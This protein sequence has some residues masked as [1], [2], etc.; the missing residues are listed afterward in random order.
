LKTRI[1]EGSRNQSRSVGA[2]R[3]RTIGPGFLFKVLVISAFAFVIRLVPLIFR[4]GSDWAI[5]NNSETYMQLTSGLRNGCGFAAWLGDKCASPEISRT[6]GYPL[7]LWMLPTWRAALFT[8]AAISAA[9]CLLVGLFSYRRWGAGVGLLATILLAVD[10]PTIVYSNKIMTEALFTAL[11]TSGFLLELVALQRETLELRFWLLALLA[12]VL[13][14]CAILV[15]PIGEILILLIAVP[16]FIIRHETWSRRAT[17][18]LV[19]VSL[20]VLTIVGWSQ[21]N[22]QQSGIRTF[23]TVAAFNLYAFRAAGVVAHSSGRSLVDVWSNWPQVNYEDMSARAIKIMLAH[24]F[25]TTYM[26]FRGLLYVALIPDRFP[27]AKLLGTETTPQVKDPGSFRLFQTLGKLGRTPGRTLAS[28][29]AEECDSSLTMTAL[30]FFQ[31]ATL[32]FV[33]IGV[34]FAVRG[35][36]LGLFNHGVCLILALSLGIFLLVLASGPEATSRFRIPAMPFLSMVAAVG[37]IKDGRFERHCRHGRP[38]LA[39]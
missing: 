5:A 19:L 15:R 30:L 25:A 14:A 3:A 6:P 27:L 37:W 32:L 21:R 16:P 33:W 12:S 9:L 10:L 38:H 39:G 26:T 35:L 29:Y 31:V 17:I 28:I 24:P 2:V 1:D 7:F 36:Y 18:A 34:L 13:I 22:W 23:S 20:S 4:G 8:Q 11:F